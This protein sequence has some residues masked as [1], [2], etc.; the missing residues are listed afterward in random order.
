MWANK[1]HSVISFNSS[2]TDCINKNCAVE[3]KENVFLAAF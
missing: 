3:W 2:D 1:V